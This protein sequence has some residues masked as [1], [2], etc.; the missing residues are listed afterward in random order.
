MTVRREGELV[1]WTGW[2]DPANQGVYLPELRFAA[3]QYGAEVLRAG[4]DRGWEWPGGA[5]ARLLEAALRGREDWLARWE[6]ELESVLA[7]RKQPDRIHLLLR[8]PPEQADTDLPW[9]QFGMTFPISAD[10]PSE[11]AVHLEARLISGDPRAT[12]EVW[13]G[14]YD[15]EQLGYPWP[16]VDPL[17]M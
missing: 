3:G 2:R 17:V 9:I 1:V 12:A 14:S 10:D 11:Q 6:C 13:G 8:H 16:P 15:A 7:S 4:E 5:V